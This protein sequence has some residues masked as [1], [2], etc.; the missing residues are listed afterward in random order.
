L[1]IKDKNSDSETEND[2]AK[3]IMGEPIHISNAASGLKG[4][5]CMGCEKEM[6][7]V[8]RK[9]PLYQ[10]YFRHHALNVDKDN[11]ECVF[12]S[13]VYRERL[14]EQILRR[15]KELKVPEVYKYPP[16]GVVGNPILLVEKTTIQAASVISQLSFYEDESGE[17][18]WGKN[19][20][21]DDRYLLIRPDVTFFDKEDK[22]ILFVE[23][24]ITHKIPDEK[25]VK[26]KRLGINTVQII[27]PKV[28]EE[29]IEKCLKSV[30]KV[31]WV[32]N[33]IESNTEYIPV[34]E[35]NSEGIPFIDEEQRKLFEESYSCRAAQV[36]NLIRSINRCVES[37]SYKRVEFQFE[38]EISRIKDATKEHQSR[39]DAI[40]AGI[41]NEVRSELESRREKLTER[42]AKF[43]ERSSDLEG[44]YL[45]RRG[46]IKQEQANTDRE[47]KFRYRVGISEEDIRREFGVEETRIDDDQK[48]VSRQEGY[49]DIDTREESRFA[50]NFESRKAELGN[51]FG[52]LEK[53]EQDKFRKF[54][55]AEQEDFNELKRRVEPENE[56]HRTHQVEIENEL[57]SEFERRYEQI[58][59]RISE[60]DVREG[61]EL[62]GRIKTILEL[63]G[64]LDNYGNEK[65]TLEKYRKGI[66]NIKNGTWKD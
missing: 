63:R 33:E 13:K 65:S 7:A 2:W 17:V 47:I 22:P 43:N 25:K 34:L 10:S 3:D 55:R 51:E 37:E 24:V 42:R 12:A 18:K 58:A 30:T 60:R 52:D 32:Y 16:K 50:D 59:D 28:P 4:Y 6:Q 35:G 41:E 66:S 5:Y 38:R 9:N 49:I 29:E 48:I 53:D 15:L 54:E 36:G 20:K 45:K 1:S 39:L 31:K 19:P 23:F 56:G 11:V 26:L 44:R 27:I 64:L 62:S 8:K 57:R 21:I 14:A 46:E 40:Q 61:D